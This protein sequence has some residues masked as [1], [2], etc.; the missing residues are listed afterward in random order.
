MSAHYLVTAMGGDIGGSVVRC[1]RKEFPKEALLGCDITPYVSEREEVG[2]FFLVPPYAEEERYIQTLLEKCKQYEITHVLPMTEGEIKLFDR[3]R[4]LF[5]SEGL[6]VMINRSDILQIAFSKFNTAEAVEKMGLNS[7]ETWRTSE[8]TEDLP[9]PV[10]V[11]PDDGCGSRGIRIIR[12]K[13]EYKR[14]VSQK[15]DMIVQEYIGTPEEEYT[16]GLFSNG[17][18]TKS[19]AFRRSIGYGGMSKMVERVEDEKIDQTARTVAD[20][21]KLEGAINIQMRKQN[22]EYYIFEINPRISSTVGFRYLLGFKDVRWWL[23]LLDGKK[24]EI[25]YI[26][27][28]KPVV[29]IRTLGEKIYWGGVLGPTDSCFLFPG[30]PNNCT[31][32]KFDYRYVA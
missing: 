17:R 29:G 16:V 25:C 22:G 5:A 13:Q 2:E 30:N 10:I 6:K 15:A 23:D 27:E 26:P 7:P 8:T 3:H 14:A 21:F 32:E 19:I 20:A 11:K 1:L 4:E 28:K 31:A 12:D 18:D 9:Y 24:E